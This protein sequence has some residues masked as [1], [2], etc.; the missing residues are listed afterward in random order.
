MKIGLSMLGESPYT[1]NYIC[2]LYISMSPPQCHS[3][4]LLYIP[5]KFVYSYQV[6]YYSVIIL[7]LLRGT[8]VWCT[9]VNT[10]APSVLLKRESRRKYYSRKRSS[11]VYIVIIE[12]SRQTDKRDTGRR[13]NFP[14]TA[15]LYEKNYSF[16]YYIIFYNL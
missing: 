13:L 3:L 2:I 8:L 14:L 9:L 5:T 1:Y 11:A 10:R 16:I 15:M 12:P 4:D 6:L 7:S